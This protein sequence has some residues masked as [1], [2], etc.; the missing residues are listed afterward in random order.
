MT[1]KQLSKPDAEEARNV[2]QAAVVGDGRQGDVTSQYMNQEVQDPDVAAANVHAAI[3]Q[4]IIESANL[5]SVLEYFESEK[6]EAFENRVVLIEEATWRESEFDTGPP[7]YYSLMIKDVDTGTRHLI[8]TGEQRI[9][10]Q[11]WKFQEM[12]A[13]PLTVVVRLAKKA[14]RFGRRLAAFTKPEA[15]NG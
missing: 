10:A 8:N 3:I 9:M 2:V 6:L 12:K 14:N 7:V 15:S 4:R 1:G 5:D 13:I 11:C